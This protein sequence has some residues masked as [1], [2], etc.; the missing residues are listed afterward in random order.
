MKVG[1]NPICLNDGEESRILS[2]ND[3][4]EKLII[5]DLTPIIL[6]LTSSIGSDSA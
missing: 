3:A 6:T 1:D 4:F 2:I 5:Q